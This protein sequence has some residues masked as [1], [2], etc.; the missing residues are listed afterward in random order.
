[1]PRISIK[2]LIESSAHRMSHVNR[3]SS[4]PVVRKENVA[5]HS[6][7][8][9]FYAYV[10]G[11][12]LNDHGQPVDFGKL[13]SRALLHDI[14]ESHT[15]D[16]L[17]KVKYAHPGLKGVLNQIS[18]SMVEDMEQ[19]LGIT[20]VADWRDAKAEDLEGDIIKFVDLLRVVSYLWEELTKGNLYMLKLFPECGDYLRELHESI[21][22]PTIL[23]Y[24]DDTIEWVD[25]TLS[26]G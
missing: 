4:V 5:E 24:V 11:S 25:E 1:M 20:L 16:F 7:F 2:R 15:G 6:W 21:T 10:V 13:L 3:Y 9:A 22:D 8:V 17:R 23:A 14:D 18:T 19:D 26:K 12:Y